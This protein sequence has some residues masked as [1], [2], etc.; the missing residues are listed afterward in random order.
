MNL[1]T[2]LLS[3]ISAVSTAAI[4][5]SLLASSAMAAPGDT[6]ATLQNGQVTGCVTTIAGGT[7]LNFGTYKWSGTAYA[8]DPG[9]S[10]P[11]S[12]Q[13]TRSSNN[14]P[15]ASCPAAQVSGTPL[16]LN[17]DGTTIG[18]TVGQIQLNGS[19]ALS[20]TAAD[21]SGAPAIIGPQ[22]ANT[23]EIPV[24]LTGTPSSTA[25]IGTYSGTIT[26]TQAAVAP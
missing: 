3:A 9:S 7:S 5:A 19:Q 8:Y 16:T 1:R 2:K 4:G 6:S 20:G 15:G 13:L 25:P 22:T 11:G 12:L 26:I 24:A 14:A 18:F 21:L 17:N 23:F 10:T